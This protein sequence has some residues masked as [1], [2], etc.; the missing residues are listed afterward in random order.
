MALFATP[1][2]PIVVPTSEQHVCR[3]ILEPKQAQEHVRHIVLDGIFKPSDIEAASRVE[4]VA[5]LWVPFW[6]VDVSVDGFHLD[7]S[8]VS[9]G[10]GNARIPIPT[11]GANHKDAVVMMSARAVF[12][13]EPKLPVTFAATIDSVEPLVVGTGELAARANVGDAE[14]AGGEELAPDVPKADAEAAAARMVVRAVH[15]QSALYAKYEPQIR[16]TLFC[17]YP[18]YYAR[19]S[20]E[21][22]VRRH[23]GEEFYVAVS[24]RTGKAVSAHH[25]SPMRAAA[26]KLRKLIS[27]GMG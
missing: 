22:S 17:L 5:L 12:P 25:P 18:V 15:P 10:R 21:G 13:Y 2:R 4:P 6:R 23:S 7:I 3:R 1:E 9:V 26:A 24:G 11:G 27:F 20:Y 16:S 8:R 19:Y 14:L